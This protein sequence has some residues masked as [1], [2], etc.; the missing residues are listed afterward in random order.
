MLLSRPQLVR[1]HFLVSLPKKQ[2]DDMVQLFGH[3]RCS[4]KRQS[5]DYSTMKTEKECL[6]YEEVEAARDFNLHG[7]FFLS[8]SIIYRN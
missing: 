8:Q 2:Q 4:L 6:C 5:P 1:N 7:I 3:C